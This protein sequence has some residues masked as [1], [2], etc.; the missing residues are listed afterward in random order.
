MAGVRIDY[1]VF[2]L[3]NWS[4][5]LLPGL[6]TGSSWGIVWLT[7]PLSGTTIPAHRKRL[8]PRFCSLSC[9]MRCSSFTLQNGELHFRRILGKCS[10]ILDIESWKG[11]NFAHA[12]H[13]CQHVPFNGLGLTGQ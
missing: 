9:P 2:Y 8:A 4:N 10:Q 7:L 11:I 1:Q 3:I 12:A 13:Y 5:V 6:P